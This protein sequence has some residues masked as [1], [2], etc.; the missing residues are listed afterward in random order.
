ME[1]TH[2]LSNHT[3]DLAKHTHDLAKHTHT[4]NTMDVP[5]KVS[6]ISHNMNETNY[7]S[8][9]F[10][11]STDRTYAAAGGDGGGSPAWHNFSLSGKWQG[12]SSEPSTNT[13]GAPSNNTSGTP[14]TNT[15]GASSNSNTTYNGSSTDTESRPNNY[16]YIIWKRIA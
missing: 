13:S 7:D 10:S 5:G 15:S 12:K 9:P 4:G 1:H 6:G 11:W 16:S 8:G 14:S 2:S 3:H